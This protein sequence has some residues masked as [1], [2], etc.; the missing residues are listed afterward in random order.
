M[1]QGSPKPT[2]VTTDD[3][4]RLSPIE[5]SIMDWCNLAHAAHQTRRR[6]RARRHRSRTQVPIRRY[7]ETDGDGHMNPQGAPTSA[8]MLSARSHRRSDRCRDHR[9]QVRRHLKTPR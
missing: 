2:I 7:D 9:R 4:R 3:P 8:L 6:R 1:S 5:S